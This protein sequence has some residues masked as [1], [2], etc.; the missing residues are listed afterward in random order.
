MKFAEKM[1]DFLAPEWLQFHTLSNVIRQYVYKVEWAWTHF[2]G[3]EYT[4]LKMTSIVFSLFFNSVVGHVVCDGVSEF[5][6][7]SLNSECFKKH[8]ICSFL[9]FIQL[10]MS[11]E[12][13]QEI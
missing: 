10:L 1:P 3:I 11:D 5:R 12:L 2:Y 7:L 6:L 8:S 9:W 13:N 4:Q